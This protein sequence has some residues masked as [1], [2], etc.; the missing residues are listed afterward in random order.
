MFAAFQAVTGLLQLYLLKSLY[1]SLGHLTDSDRSKTELQLYTLSEELGMAT[2]F[3]AWWGHAKS[4]L[5][6]VMSG[7]AV[8]LAIMTFAMTVALQQKLGNEYSRLG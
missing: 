2:T 1:L 7:L 4:P 6:P 3:W 8:S 5:G